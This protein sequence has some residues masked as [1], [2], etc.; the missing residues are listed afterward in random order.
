MRTDHQSAISAIRRSTDLLRGEQLSSGDFAARLFDLTSILFDNPLC[1]AALDTVLA[2]RTAKAD[3]FEQCRRTYVQ[4]IKSDLQ[5]FCKG[6]LKVVDHIQSTGAI[7]PDK[8]ESLRRAFEILGKEI[9]FGEASAPLHTI[10][11]ELVVDE[12]VANLTVSKIENI[13]TVVLSSGA[14]AIKP[15]KDGLVIATSEGYAGVLLG[16]IDGAQQELKSQ[17]AQAVS[18]LTFAEQLVAAF[19]LG[20]I[21]D[22]LRRRHLETNSLI[23]DSALQYKGELADLARLQNFAV[24]TSRAL[25]IAHLV[26]ARLQLG[27]VENHSLTR[28][29]VHLERFGRAQLMTDFDAEEASAGNRHFEARLQARVDAFLFAEG[30]YPITHAEA[31]GGPI[32]TFVGENQHIFQ[33][34]L[35]DHQVPV[36]LEL[37][38]AVRDKTTAAKVRAKLDLALH[39]ADAYSAHLRA[40]PRW[41]DHRVTALVAYD[42]PK[43]FRTRRDGALLVYLGPAKPHEGAVFLE[44]VTEA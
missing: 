41:R 2:S 9:R 35:N 37:K 30:L 7:I 42:G 20:P 28:L 29:R 31:S 44:D 26:E 21:V 18:T 15:L 13:R 33:E 5:R 22:E 11:S 23:Q 27:V 6:V 19:S 8:A 12:H 38:V 43:R 16:Q 3:A 39:Q 32:D 24:P 4:S 34:V 36:L 10:L 14:D 25:L 1:S 17:L 40:N